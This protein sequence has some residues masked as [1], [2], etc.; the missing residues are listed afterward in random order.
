MVN[1]QP[2]NG[3]TNI[4]NELA[5]QFQKLHLSGNEW[6]I[7]WVVLRKTWGWHKKEDTISL[8]Q[9]QKA[10]GLSRPSVLE[11]INK[12][13]GKKVLLS[14]KESYITVYAFNKHYSEWIVPKKG[15]V[16]FSVNTSREKGTT[17]VPKKEPKLVPKK[18]HT[19]TNKTTI[20][21]TTITKERHTSIASL[22]DAA[23]QEIADKYQVPLSF[24]H[25]KL[26]D[27]TNWLRAKGRSY[28]DYKAALSNWV[29]KDALQIRQ[30]QHDK[31]KLVVID[32]G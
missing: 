24:V 1:P 30:S 11:A 19:K 21:K 31:S 20:T 29:K 12:L 7:V 27:M 2:E 5:D 14:K 22:D 3:T 26:D 32:P 6:Q 17:L 13:V 15:L 25:S 4:A 10:T 18:E 23:L 16:G 9:F 28:R 8:T